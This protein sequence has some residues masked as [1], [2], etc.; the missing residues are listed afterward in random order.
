MGQSKRTKK[1]RRYNGGGRR[2]D[3]T[4]L[5]REEAIQRQTEYDA[6]SIDQKLTR[7]PP[8][9]ACAKQRAKLLAQKSGTKTVKSS[10]AEVKEEKV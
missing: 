1:D 10:K 9:P 8:E 4:K 5:K 3:L 6:L 7:L 2:P